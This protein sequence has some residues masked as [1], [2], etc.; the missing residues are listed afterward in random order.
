MIPCPICGCALHRLPPRDTL[1]VDCGDWH[2][3]NTDPDVCLAAY[4]RA[5]HDEFAVF[6]DDPTRDPWANTDE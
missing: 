1:S 5:R 6:L 4:A 2:H 3:A